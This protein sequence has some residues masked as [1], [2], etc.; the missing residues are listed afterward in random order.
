LDVIVH[1][2]DKPHVSVAN[3]VYASK[4][5]INQS[6]YRQ[7]LHSAPYKIWTTALTN[8]K[9]YNQKNSKSEIKADDS[10]HKL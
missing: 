6:L 3:H 5:T 1:A 9:I 2:V 7:K 10:E 4:Y 8:V